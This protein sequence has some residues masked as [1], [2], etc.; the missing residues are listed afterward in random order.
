[1]LDLFFE[2]FT[3]T[4]VSCLVLAKNNISTYCHYNTKPCAEAQGGMI[5]CFSV[6]ICK[7]NNH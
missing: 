3:G 6:K 2:T 1:M 7:P 4:P 5:C